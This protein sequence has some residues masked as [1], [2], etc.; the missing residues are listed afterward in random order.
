VFEAEQP[1]NDL[2]VHTEVDTT[3]DDDFNQDPDQLGFG[4]GF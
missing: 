1:V 2:V 3:F 4:L